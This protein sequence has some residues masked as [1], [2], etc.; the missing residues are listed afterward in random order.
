MALRCLS[1]SILRYR[2]VD[3][4]VP[5]MW[6]SL[7]AARVR[8]GL[9]SGGEVAE[10]VAVEMHHAAVRAGVGIELGGALDKPHASVR[11]D[12]L[13]AAEAAV[14]Q[15]IEEGAPTR[16]VLLGALDDAEDLPVAIA[17]HRGGHQQR[18]I[19]HLAGPA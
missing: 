2:L 6:R 16:L 7:A 19:T 18:A 3:Q 5:A 17:I 14:L 10:G 11:D 1:S 13:D 15:M 12:Q 8:A 9:R 4:R